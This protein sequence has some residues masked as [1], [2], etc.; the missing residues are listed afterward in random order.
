MTTTLQAYCTRCGGVEVTVD[1]EQEHPGVGTCK[2]CGPGIYIDDRPRHAIYA[3]GDPVV[4]SGR[5]DREGFTP[6]E[7]KAL[8]RRRRDSAQARTDDSK[9]DRFGLWRCG[10]C[11]MVQPCGNSHNTG[12]K[13]TMKFFDSDKVGCYLDAIGHRV[14]KT[15]DGKEIKM[16][17]LT[18]RVQPLTAELANALDPDVRNLLFNMG[19]ALPKSKLKA[20]HFALT[21]P[22]QQLTIAV[23]PELDARI[24][25][26][27][28][29]IGDVRAR[30]EKGV[31]GFGLVFYAAYGPASPADLEYICDWLTQQRF[32]TFEE[33]QPALNFDNRPATD[34]A[35]PPAPP[36]AR[37]PRRQ[38]PAIQPG[39]E[40][41]DGVHAEH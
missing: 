1:R 35:Q 38:G 18:L 27:D 12:R 5:Y 39:D 22:K 21:V 9:Q 37:G 36:R 24:V 2:A 13:T 16:V 30:T 4:L 17:D 10:T 14:E 25:L 23:L 34:A 40:I 11:G 19:D 31:D 26:A 8:D 29:E 3:A 7:R 28:C 33:Q 41:R 6:S 20:I 15:K 32:V